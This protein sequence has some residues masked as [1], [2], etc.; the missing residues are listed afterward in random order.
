LIPYKN[1]ISGN[2]PDLTNEY[3]LN[4]EKEALQEIYNFGTAF[5]LTIAAI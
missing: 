1:A 4:S 5:K 2:I 3:P